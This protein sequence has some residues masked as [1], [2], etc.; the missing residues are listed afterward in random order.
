MAAVWQTGKLG[1]AYYDVDT[2]CIYA[3]LDKQENDSF[4]LLRQGLL[5]LSLYLLFYYF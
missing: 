1:V 4:K 5:G 2:T 3:M